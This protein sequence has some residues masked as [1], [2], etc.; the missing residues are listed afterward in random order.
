MSPIISTEINIEIPC[1]GPDKDRLVVGRAESY[2]NA[3]FTGTFP[4][5]NENPISTCP[6]YE[7]RPDQYLHDFRHG[8]LGAIDLYQLQKANGIYDIMVEGLPDKLM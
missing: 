7:W 8:V 3:N 5:E 2:F 6:E 1:F 4:Y